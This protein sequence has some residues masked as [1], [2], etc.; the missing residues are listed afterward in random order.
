MLLTSNRT[1]SFKFKSSV[2][3]VYSPL[4]AE[5]PA[6]REAIRTCIDL[7]LKS[8]A[9]ESDSAQLIK[10]I[11]LE[12]PLSE[13]YETL[14]DISYFSSNFDFVFFSWIPRERNIL[15]DALTKD[16]LIVSGTMVVGDAFTAPN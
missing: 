10:T 6:L 16:A 4:L 3:Y 7:G 15:T 9:F 2:K 5:G 14:A 13:L 11:N 1:Q 8:A 12:T